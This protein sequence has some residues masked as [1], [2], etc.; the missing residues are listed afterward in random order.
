MFWESKSFRNDILS[1]AWFVEHNDINSNSLKLSSALS[2]YG[3]LL[4]LPREFYKIYIDITSL[5]SPVRIF[6]EMNILIFNIHQ[7]YMKKIIA[8]LLRCYQVSYSVSSL[9]FTVFIN[10]FVRFLWRCPWCD[11]YRRWKWTRRPEFKPSTIMIAF[12]RA[13]IFLGKVWIQ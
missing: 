10:Y 4:L 2:K 6:L 3:E 11:C 8:F 13:L 1:T 9:K 7:L 5:K 12:H